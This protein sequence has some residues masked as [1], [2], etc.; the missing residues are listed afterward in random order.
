MSE[1]KIKV[2]YIVH[3]LGAEGI[4]SF[5]CN[6][7]KN[8][9]H[10]KFDV[11]LIMAINRNGILQIRE[12]EILD[13]GVKVLRTCDLGSLKKVLKHLK[14]L[15]QL[16]IEN[17]PF[18]VV[19][20]NFDKLDGFNLYIAKKVKIPV[21]ISH[22][23]TANRGALANKIK[24]LLVKS[25]E[26]LSKYLIHKCATDFAG[27][28]DVACKYLHPKDNS[29]VIINGVDVNKFYYTSADLNK[30]REDF[31]LVNKKVV[32][33]VARISEVK[34]PFFMA[35]VVKMLSLIRDDF[36]FI[37]IGDGEKSY[38][39]KLEKYIIDNNLERYFKLIGIRNDV[40][41]FLH[42]VDVFC[43]PSLFEGLPISVIEAQ[44]AGCDC[45]ISDTVTKLVDAGKST[46]LPIGESNAKLWAE[47]INECLNKDRVALPI[48]IL[49]KFD[50]K[51][52]ARE[53]ENI[54]FKV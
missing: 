25:Y 38:R 1:N 30:Y 22:S 15:K 13:C 5:T 42:I 36:V 48:E 8:L 6:L 37:W 14:L 44:V 50:N 31:D 27:C 16:L 41:D 19:H 32:G 21:R 54:Y 20:S 2:A 40:S 52:M 47:K 12:Q 49:E 33:I 34:N 43:L 24:E 28:S 9:D 51:V 17:G 29:K 45:I 11:T 3:G 4:S 23:H 18:D 10:S 53:V 35:D 26:K 39:E 7:I 46:F